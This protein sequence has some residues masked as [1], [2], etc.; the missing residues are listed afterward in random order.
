MKEDE[1]AKVFHANLIKQKDISLAGGTRGWI[2]LSC[3]VVWS[4]ARLSLRGVNSLG[5]VGMKRALNCYTKDVNW[6]DVEKLSQT[7]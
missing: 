2:R 1:Y 4:A 5:G 3:P 7:N 6:K